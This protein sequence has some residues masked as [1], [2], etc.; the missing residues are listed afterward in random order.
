MTKRLYKPTV[1]ELEL[2]RQE[3]TSNG[4]VSE[5]QWIQSNC[6]LM[7]G[8]L[9]RDPRRYRS[10]GPYWWVM[11]KAMI[12]NGISDFGDFVDREWLELADY[13]NTFHNLLA[14]WMYQDMA[15]DNG[16]IYSNDHNV[17]FEPEEEGMERDVQVYTLV[18]DDMEI[19]AFERA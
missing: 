11:K 15:V 3:A 1:D 16:L 6:R 13:G 17:A 12:D 4:K 5:E 18:D 8:A 19:L 9:N 10:Y 2:L 7:Q 14:A